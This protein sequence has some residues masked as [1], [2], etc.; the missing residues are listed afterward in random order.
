MS[1]NWLPSSE[2]RRLRALEEV[3]GRKAGQEASRIPED[4]QCFISWMNSGRDLT[5][6]IYRKDWIISKGV[7]DGR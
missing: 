5:W 4:E 7:Q 2:Y 3:A 6:E 1:D